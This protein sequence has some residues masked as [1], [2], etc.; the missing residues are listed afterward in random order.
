MREQPR[1]LFC[2]CARSRYQMKREARSAIALQSS[3]LAR[4]ADASVQTRSRQQEISSSAAF[5]RP[6]RGKARN[7]TDNY[8]LQVKSTAFL[9]YLKLE[10]TTSPV[11]LIS[12]FTTPHVKS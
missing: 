11:L 9:D 7:S 5:R 6:S 4:A 1:Q 12:V 10:F 3:A 8:Y 2:I